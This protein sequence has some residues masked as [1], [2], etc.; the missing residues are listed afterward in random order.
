MFCFSPLQGG[1]KSRDSENPGFECMLRR[2]S[3]VRARHP[4]FCNLPLNARRYTQVRCHRTKQTYGCFL[5][6]DLRDVAKANFWLR[7]ASPRRRF[8]QAAVTM[9]PRPKPHSGRLRAPNTHGAPERLPQKDMCNG[10]KRISLWKMLVQLD[11]R[12]SKGFNTC[13]LSEKQPKTD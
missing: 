6:V 10:P 1:C 12:R 7:V 13:R 4:C 2:R 3:G 8:C 11:L 5:F 9:Y